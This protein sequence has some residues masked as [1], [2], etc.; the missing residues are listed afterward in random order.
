[1]PPGGARH[2]LEIVRIRRHDV[3]TVASQQHQRR[4]DDIPAASGREQL[5]GSPS[6]ILV[7]RMNVDGAK[8]LRQQRLTRGLRS[9]AGDAQDI[10]FLETYLRGEYD[11]AT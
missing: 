6:Q 9:F 1:M 2:R 11:R 7:E 5:A 3:I 10:E 4:I 8:S